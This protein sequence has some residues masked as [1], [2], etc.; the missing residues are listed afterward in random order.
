MPDQDSIEEKLKLIFNSKPQAPIYNI[1]QYTWDN[2][3]KNM[4][5]LCGY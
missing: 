3:A 4:I 5:S 2:V 1:E